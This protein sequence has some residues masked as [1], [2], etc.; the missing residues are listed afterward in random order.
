MSGKVRVPEGLAGVEVAESRIAKSDSDGTLLY[1]GYPI[2]DI[3]ERASFEETAFL[4]LRGSLPRSADLKSFK[5]T[6]SSEKTPGEDVLR[7]MAGMPATSH[8]IDVLRTA[9]SFL[10]TSNGPSGRDSEEMSLAAKM[11]VLAANCYRMPRR[12]DAALPTPGLSFAE[13]LLR[14]LTGRAPDQRDV[15]FFE[16]VL[17][18]YMEHDLNASSFTVRVVAST[19]ADPYAAVTAGLAALK[20]PLHGG[21]NEA[22]MRMI[23]EVG[24]PSR[25]RGYIEESLAEGKKVVGFGHRVYKKFDPRAKLCKGYLKQMA[26]THESGAKLYAVCD[27]LEETMWKRKSI[28][29]N[30]D[31]YAAPIFY[32]LGI[33]IP[34]YTPIFASSRVFGWL[35][36]YNEQVENNKLIRPDA[37]YVGAI[38]LKY[39]PVEL[40]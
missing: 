34:L 20:G 26:E 21:A 32:L 10:G 40:R 4:V 13:D 11:S 31:F 19:L 3:A 17:I 1:R 12:E 22:A 8:P 33:E 24:E 25:A 30:L 37:D 7:L 28:P 9:V 6:L 5:A 15:W 27:A 23:L 2:E 38:G 39:V 14:M 36:H 18:F 29:P 16:R 35:A